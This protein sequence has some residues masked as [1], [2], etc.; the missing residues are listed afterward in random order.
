LAFGIGVGNCLEIGKRSGREIAVVRD[1]LDD[2][3]PAPG[4]DAHSLIEGLQRRPG[5]NKKEQK[6]L[7]SQLVEACE[8]I[9]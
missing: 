7:L 4:W 5:C 8:P 9:S 3:K 6:A 2:K 1:A